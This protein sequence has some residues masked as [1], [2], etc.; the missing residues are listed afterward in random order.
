VFEATFEVMGTATKKKALKKGKAVLKKAQPP[1]QNGFDASKHLGKWKL[2]EG[3][4]LI[5]KRLRDEWG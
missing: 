2:E 1:K 3:G 5:Q 4:L